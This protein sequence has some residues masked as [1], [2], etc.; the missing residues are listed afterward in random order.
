MGR[1][2]KPDDKPASAPGLAFRV[3]RSRRRPVAI[4]STTARPKPDAGPPPRF[5][6]AIKWLE[7]VR[8]I[9]GV[10]AH[11]LVLHR[12]CHILRLPPHLHRDRRPRRAVLAGVVQQ[13]VEQLP[14]KLLAAPAPTPGLSVVSRSFK[15]AARSPLELEPARRSRTQ[16]TSSIGSSSGHPGLALRPGHEQQRFDDL[17]QPESFTVNLVEHPPILIDRALA[18]PRDL[19]LAQQR[20]QRRAQLVRG[21]TRESLLPL[22][23]LVQP[24]EQAR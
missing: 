14:Q 12:Q 16:S 24:V 7:N 5:R 21:I 1:V 19:K 8:Q 6:R 15:S 9:R 22:E 10:N 17:T 20:R 18:P 3:H 13:V 23:F 11:A 2:R 4:R